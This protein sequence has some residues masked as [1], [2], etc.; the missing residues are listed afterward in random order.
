MDK[1]LTYSPTSGHGNGTITLSASTLSELEDRVAT[2]IVSNS[3]YSLSAST[4]VT[5]QG[6]QLT[7]ITF[8]NVTWV[9][10]VP[11]SGGTATKDNCTYS[12]TAYYSDGTTSDV[13]EY[14][15]VSGSLNVA[16]TTTVDR[17]DA[18]TLTLSAS[19][20]EFTASTNVTVYQAAP[21]ITGISFN[22]LTW[23]N[24]V[25]ATGGTADKNNCS[26]EVIALCNDGVRLDITSLAAVSGSLNVPVSTEM[27]RQNVGTLNLT[28]TYGGLSASTSVSAYQAA[29]SITGIG[30]T[31]LVWA[32]DVPASGGTATKDNCTYTVYAY[33]D[34]N[35][36]TDITD[37]AVITGSLVVPAT[38]ATTRENVGTLVLTASY[39][40]FSATSSVTAYQIIYGADEYLTFEIISGGTIYFRRNN[41]SIRRIT[42]SYS[43]D[44]GETWANFESSS[45]EVGP[46]ISVQSGDVVLFKGDNARYCINIAP[47]RY[48]S[49]SGTTARF[50][51]KGN[52]M[53]LIN[54]TEF[55]TISTLS[56]EYTFYH[57]FESCTGLTSAEHLILPAITLTSWCYTGMFAGCTSLTTAP[58]LYAATLAG[59]CYA[60]MFQGCTS[61][62]TAPELPATTLKTYCYAYMFEGC[63]SLTS[64][65]ELN[66]TT[67]AVGCYSR[68][69]K[70]CTGIT[71]VPS[72]YLPAIELAGYCYQSMFNSCTS[73][74]TAPELPATTLA[75]QCYANMFYGC[76]SLKTAPA[77]PAT[78]LPEGC[79]FRMFVNCASLTTAPVSIGTS[80]STL[81]H[82]CCTDMFENCT[83]L[84]TAPE[85]PSTSLATLCYSGM[86]AGCTSLTSAPE[87]PAT[88]L[89]G[90]CYANMF[91]GC[92]SLTV[93]PE[94]PATTL[95]E[96]CYVNMFYGC[97]S[98]TTAPV[99][100]G[101]SA[102]TLAENCCHSMF[103]GCTSLTT[104]PELP[105]TN[106]AY[107]CYNEMFYG[108][109]SLNYIKCLSIHDSAFRYTDD[110]VYGV[111]STGT[112][113][114]NPDMNDWTTGVSGIPTDWI[115][116][117]Y[118][119]TGISISDLTWVIDIPSS[120][121]TAD[122][123]NCSYS[124]YA[125]YNNGTV[126]DITN[127]ATVS[128]SLNVSASTVET[129][130]SAGTL[131]LTASYSGFT[132][133][134][135]ID[136]YQEANITDY[137]KEYL[138]LKILSDGVIRWKTGSKSN[139]KTI[140]YSKDN[141]VT[142]TNI[143]SSTGGTKIFVSNGDKIKFKGDN[144]S[145]NG[146][147]LIEDYY[148]PFTVQGNIMSLIDSEGFATATTLTSTNTFSSFFSSSDC[149]S[150]ENLVLPATTLTD[151][152][153][154]NMFRS[155]SE[156]T[157][158]PS[159]LP[160]TTLATNCYDSMFRDCS[161]L[162][163]APA[164]PATTLA[165]NCYVN[166]FRNCTKLTTAPS[167]L[168]A[169]TLATNCYEFMFD[170][171]TS[172]T[173]A[174]ELSATT[175]ANNCCHYMFRGCTGLTTAPSVLP[176]TTLVN[177]CYLQ[178]FMNC[179]SLTTAPE[180]PA[181]TLAERCY[182][183]MFDGCTS[184]NYIKCLATDISAT[185]CTSYWVDGVAST[186]TFIKNP[187]M[188][189]WTTGPSGIPKGWTITNAS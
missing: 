42:I 102:A 178:M 171:C 111:A 81:A 64:V 14:V 149:K 170:N 58:I 124:V 145:Y 89:A 134:N 136:V 85:L 103:Q 144:E 27:T 150:A 139:T 160:A 6:A 79:Y 5:Q 112:F 110:W 185:Y 186:G 167:V 51:I 8:E 100:I 158:P 175:L 181:T 36:S 94:L 115:V 4:S 73:L 7:A 60:N 179:T 99:S 169:T 132:D 61:L 34:T 69:F 59:D 172:L 125:N 123:N 57:I 113:V 148:V 184:L 127:Q 35:M 83:S 131:T 182:N 25:P 62:T 163:T 86:F 40:A 165:D 96:L 49:F 142:W 50:N 98:L 121:G 44:D 84:T 78:D 143:T 75:N 118:G 88:T 22:N 141:G 30:F 156:L 183:G 38:T 101:T 66:A 9:T 90:R 10:D 13:T 104:A 17:H 80:A 159:V 126:I 63:T 138:T 52:I 119:L 188:T 162:T 72:D 174:P 173:I 122:K 176:A 70:N 189:S 43:K 168:P 117:N 108:C 161:S 65:P 147:H 2:I 135:S 166:M 55:E 87:L 32:M 157:T 151:N 97:T 54:S 187:N 29:P 12:V 20:S 21:S 114:K 77:L 180:L 15:T 128:G 133:S 67:L 68:M 93:A 24:D 53:S 31:S 109:T 106:L 11:S 47:D 23:I 39:D 48:Y 76:T 137:S 152:C 74:T 41:D 19:Y 37:V 177:S 107:Y 82:E 28:A 153:Y 164:L 33:Y 1:W 129:R 45:S 91:K 26:Y 92:T 146:N 140:S 155:C 95:A 56:S 18:G 154:Q 130:H 120:G 116:V 46:G 71:S 105:A 16:A 3:Q